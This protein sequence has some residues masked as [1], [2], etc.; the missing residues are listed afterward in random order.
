MK[1]LLDFVLIAALI[2]PGVSMPLTSTA[3]SAPVS[4]PAL[5]RFDEL[6]TL[7]EHETPP[8]PLA[9]KLFALLETPF[10]DNSAAAASDSIAPRSGSALQVAH[11]NIERGMSFDDIRAAMGGRFRR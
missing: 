8:E 9:H 2:I 10:V 11:W 3:D 1:C 7:Y 5:L 6:I 4:A